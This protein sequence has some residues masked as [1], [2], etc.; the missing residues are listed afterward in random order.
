M[1]QDSIATSRGRAQ[2]PGSGDDFRPCSPLWPFFVVLISTICPRMITLG[3]FP[4][5][6]EGF[7]AYWSQFMQHSLAQGQGVPDAG[8]F[9]LYSLLLS[10]VCALPG[11]VLIWLRLSDMLIAVWAGWL[12]CRLLE[13]E[14]RSAVG[15]M[16]LGLAFLCAMNAP[17]VIQAGYKNSIFAAYV[18][19]FLALNL[20]WKNGRVTTCWYVA[21]GLTALA[22]LLREPF[23]VFA[24]VGTVAV[25]LGHGPRAVWRYVAGGLLT[26][27]FILALFVLLRGG[28]ATLL[29]SYLNAE[30]VYG[31]EVARTWNKFV[32][33]GIMSVRAFWPL[34]LLTTAAFWLLFRPHGKHGN[35]FRGQVW[36]WL[37]LIL[38]PLLEPLLKIGFVYHFAVSLPGCAGLCALA[39]KREIRRFP[40]F[41]KGGI[42]LTCLACLVLITGM[43]GPAAARMTLETLRAFPAP[44]WPA[45]FMV[46]SNTLLAGA[47]IQ[48]IMPSGGMLSVSGFMHFL[49]P[50][51]GFLPPDP[52]LSDL[53]RSLIMVGYDQA[54]LAA[55]LRENPPD[56]VVVGM[57]HEEHSAIFTDALI[58]VIELSG[59]YTRQ[60]VIPVD[61]DKNYGWIG[62]IIYRK[63]VPAVE[64]SY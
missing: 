21:G 14:S 43:P 24:V 33:N 32:S 20:G 63:I 8:G 60:S 26:G 22:V 46:Q 28:I 40:G 2:D 15:G 6:D 54:R 45:R 29:Q 47:V 58:K 39:W 27:L 35:D 13:R 23:V 59:R 38:A 16:L 48:K 7:Y 52:A 19:L 44:G 61:K 50:V 41:R 31:P 42:I 62:C 57:T 3:F 9:C 56:V 49:Y 36:F 37:A 11:N 4:Y 64:N 12:L 10:P 30:A 17:P 55:L 51:T 25:W 53:S 1:R 34:L 5:M 18:P